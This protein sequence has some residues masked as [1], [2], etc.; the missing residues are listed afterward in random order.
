MATQVASI[1]AKVGADLSGF[2]AG[3]NQ[4]NTSLH[5]AGGV[6][7][8]FTAGI[9]QGIG[10]AFGMAAIRTIRTF[11][12]TITG[13]LGAAADMEQ[14]IADI[15][16]VMGLT[17][18]ET[19]K[20]D[21]LVSDLGI[22]PKLKVT[23]T[24]AAAAVEMLGRNGLSLSEILDGAARATVLL[25]NSTGG[26]FATSADVATD[27]MAQFGIE[28]ENMTWAVDQIV[29]VT[30]QSKFDLDKYRLAI[31][32]AGG[33][34]GAVGVEFDDFNAAISSIAPSFASG[35]DAG[36]S[37]KVFLQRLV[38]DTTPAANA[39]RQI[40]LLSGMTAKEFTEAEK[41]LEDYSQQ[42]AKLDPASKNYEERAAALKEKMDIL[43]KSMTEGQNAFFD[44]N[45]SLK[46]MT[47]IA[48]IL[49]VAFADLT[50]E[51]KILTA[52]NIFGTD[53]MRAAFAMAESG[54]V[55]YTD[56][57]TAAKELGVSIDEVNKFMDGGIT[58][59]EAYK[60]A[61]GDTSAEES[62][63]IRMDT[64][65]GVWEIFTGIV[66]SL[67][68]QFG[69]AFLPA[70]RDVTEALTELA[71]RLGPKVIEWGQ[72]LGERFK[73]ITDAGIALLNIGLDQGFRA[74]FD[75]LPDGTRHLDKLFEAFGMTK[76][77]ARAAS[78]RFLDAAKALGEVATAIITV[79]AEITKIVASIATWIDKTIGIDNAIRAVAALMAGSFVT[80][81]ISAIAT[82]AGIVG[83]IAT[84]VSSLGGLLAIAKV[85]GT[86]VALSISAIGGPITLVV[87]AIA[88]LALA[89]S[90]NWGDIQGKTKAA[91]EAIKNFTADGVQAIKNFFGG[92]WLEI[93]QNMVRGIVDG[94]RAGWTWLTDTAR[95]LANAAKSTAESA[96]GIG[97]PSKVFRGI[98]QNV[99]QSFA[100]GIDDTMAMPQLNI[101]KMVNHTVDA[102]P[103]ALPVGLSGE[104]GSRRIDVYLHGESNLPGDKVKLRE[105]ARA[106][107]QEFVFAG[108]R[109]AVA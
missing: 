52:T 88:G 30:R 98:G 44:T 63:A 104:G 50:E 46:S 89:W 33:V 19:T 20:V 31:A 61:I 73:M 56:A 75:T 92:G 10:Q 48:E 106:L 39:M 17:A 102:A 27:V 94:I 29:G 91:W 65:K 77:E 67:S 21:K 81:I 47:E 59:I 57:A 37:F 70:A 2:K 15:A 74:I 23:A 53:A 60:L 38:P 11:G 40:G 101:T 78:E 1:F 25:S 79:T 108:G 5:S 18:E 28:A 16:A 6:F 80:S 84:F 4:F 26:D 85:V 93:G 76:D 66:E 64:L 103:A 72:E 54:A 62:A 105:L 109:V 69:K 96:L 107:Q 58:S 12:E 82:I 41:K 32:Q 87:A 3:M 8:N 83:S 43:Q 13:T 86:G 99:G 36:T 22:D 9:V 90:Q 97:S 34:A 49:G 55:V 42:L 24:E 35:S 7:R 95:D 100:M 45:G 51:Q 14:A 68:I 71:T